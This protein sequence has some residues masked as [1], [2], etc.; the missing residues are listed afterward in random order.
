MSA[1]TRTAAGRT[2]AMHSA[3]SLVGLAA[4]VAVTLLMLVFAGPAAAN[5]HQFRSASSRATTCIRART[6]TGMG[7]ANVEVLRF[8]FDWGRA[9]VDRGQRG[10]CNASTTGRTTTS[11]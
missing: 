3:S 8:L 7:A 10:R 9:E 6:S 4:V 2:P 5:H 11:S 1:S